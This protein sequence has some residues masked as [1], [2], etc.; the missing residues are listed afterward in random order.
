LTVTARKDE[1]LSIPLADAK[2]KTYHGGE[3][4]LTIHDVRPEPNV[5]QTLVEMT[6]QARGSDLESQRSLMTV[7][8]GGTPQNPLEFVDD[9]GRPSLQWHTT[10]QMQAGDSVRMTVRLM[11]ATLT[12][13]PTH[14]RYH[15]MTRVST[16]AE[17]D[18]QDVPMP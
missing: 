15:E 4:S 11:P 9:Q 7:R 5:G 14:I 18:F 2:G 17:F 3:V 12:G 16:E 8:A 13:P 10:S 6:I 1:P